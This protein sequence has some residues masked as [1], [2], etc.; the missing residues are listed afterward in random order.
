MLIKAGERM[1]HYY[2]QSM[3]DVK[4]D[5]KTIHYTFNHQSFKFFTDHGVFSKDHVD[6]ATDL[7]LHT[8]D[9]SDAKT[10]LDLGCGYGVMGIVLNKIYACTVTMTDVNPRALEL[11]KQNISMNDARATVFKSEGFDS[12]TESYDLIITNPPIRIGK[13]SMY[14]LFKTAKTHLTK[15]GSLWL[16]MHKKH[17]ALSA[18]RFLSEHYE[19]VEVIKRHKG[20]HVVRC[21][22]ALT[23]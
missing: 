21:Q 10:A 22:K 14:E 1:S 18:I 3:D 6:S 20:F 8:V 12:V 5:V 13:E 11:T 16:V 7:L 9:P 4:S 2:S 19:S 15:Q 23:Y 17:G